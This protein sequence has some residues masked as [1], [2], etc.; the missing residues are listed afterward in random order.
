VLFIMRNEG[1]PIAEADRRFIASILHEINM[2][3]PVAHV[4]D[5]S[6]QRLALDTMNVVL[7]FLNRQSVCRS[8]HL[9]E[10]VIQYI[11]SMRFTMTLLTKVIDI[12]V[13]DDAQM[14]QTLFDAAC[15]MPNI[16]W[17]S[18]I[19]SITLSDRDNFHQF[20]NNWRTQMPDQYHGYEP[21]D[22]EHD[23]GNFAILPAAN[24]LNYVTPAEI[25]SIGELLVNVADRDRDSCHSIILNA[26]KNFYFRP[27]HNWFNYGKT[28]N[29]VGQQFA[30]LLEA[31]G[32]TLN[33]EIDAITSPG[34][35]QHVL[36][37]SILVEPFI[38]TTQ[39][40]E[41]SITLPSNFPI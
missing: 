2:V 15:A 5:H 31:V 33:F 10:L 18:I 4:T 27:I 22:Y 12:G 38:I 14:E 26:L 35:A 24:P 34:L 40:H 19:H 7:A 17:Y 37:N 28:R 9:Q 3:R 6:L 29:Q 41:R 16:F 25:A 32:I 36:E 1:V 20:H 21:G 8:R 39:N 13:V 30:A 23:N 11:A